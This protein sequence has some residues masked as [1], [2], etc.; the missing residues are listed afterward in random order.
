MF[1]S[2]ACTQTVPQNALV[3]TPSRHP[4]NRTRLKGCAGIEDE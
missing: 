2:T 1:C 4:I 3:R